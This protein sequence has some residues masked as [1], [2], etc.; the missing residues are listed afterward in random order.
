[1]TSRFRLRWPVDAPRTITQYFGENPQNYAG[2][3]FAGHEGVDFGVV[4]GSNVYACADGTVFGVRANDGHPYGIHVRV[5][6]QANGHEY[7]TVYAHLSRSVVSEHQHVRAGDVIAL[8]GNTGNSLGPHLHLTLK[9]SGAR[10]EGYP[11]GV[12]DPLPFLQ[13][14]APAPSD[15]TI[16]TTDPAVRLRAR[17]TTA[18]AQLALLDE[19]EA[20]TVLGDADAARASVGQHGQ[21]IQVQRAYGLNGFVAAWYTQLQRP[22]PTPGPTPQPQPAGPLVVY[23]AEALN[24]RN[25]PSTRTSRIAIALPHEPLTAIGDRRA[26]LAKIGDR[27]EWL[28]VRLPDDG[29]TGHVAAWYVQ[30]EPGPAPGTPLTVYP[31]EDMNMRERPTT[32]ANPPIGRPAQGAPLTVHDDPERARV[33][34][35]R[36]DEWLYVETEEGQR[37]WV[38]AW[39]VGLQ[40]PSLRLVT[41]AA[42]PAGPL[43][44]YATEAL[45]VRKGP[46]PDTSRIAIALPHEPLTVIGDP[47][48][49]LSRLGQ[50]GEWLRV[51]LPDDGRMGY[52]AA[53]YVQADPGPAPEALLTVYPTQD[54]NMRERPT[55]RARRVG[56]PARGTPLTVHDD[57]ERARALVGRYDDWLYVETA[58]GQR[59]WIA[60]WYVSTTPT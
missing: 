7:H 28:Q 35:G 19:G 23:A 31:T 48:A 40:P 2:F 38:A 17:P 10:T 8:S 15:L 50:R 21:W 41:P 44:V 1:M 26:A 59:G 3:G 46:S 34:V 60:A 18:S 13:G 43:V 27:G 56:L 32:S 54:M 4:E 53:W 30:T 9:L 37:G 22:G 6:H 24:V 11:D 5:R 12:V 39:Y 57:L 16:Y 25:G 42:A 55:V 14:Q 51:R 29:R 45:N 58:E 47:R 20:L 52:V 36:Y 33:L 49:A